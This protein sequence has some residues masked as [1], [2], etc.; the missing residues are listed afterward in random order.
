[1]L[2]AA[3]AVP[4]HLTPEPQAPAVA[5]LSEP[6]A[7]DDTDEPRRRRRRSSASS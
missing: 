5:L 2:S 6:E 1:M 7:S 3:A 4:E